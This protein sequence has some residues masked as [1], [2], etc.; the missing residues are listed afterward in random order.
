MWCCRSAA[1]I[2]ALNPAPLVFPASLTRIAM[3]RGAPDDFIYLRFE[4]YFAVTTNTLQFGAAV[5]LIIN[6][7]PIYAAGSS[8]S[9]R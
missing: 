6:A 2:P 1:S 3:V 5:E 9:T 7:G 4:G 8:A